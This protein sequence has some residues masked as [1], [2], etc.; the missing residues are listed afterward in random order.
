[1]NRIVKSG[2]TQTAVLF[3]ACDGVVHQFSSVPVTVE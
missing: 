1:L 3:N 2:V